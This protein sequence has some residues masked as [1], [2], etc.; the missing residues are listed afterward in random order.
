V[1]DKVDI[2]QFMV[3]RPANLPPAERIRRGYIHD[4]HLLSTGF[5][6]ADLFS[7]DSLSEIGRQVYTSVFCNGPALPTRTGT[8]TLTETASI[9]LALLQ[10]LPQYTAPCPNPQARDG[11]ILESLLDRSYVVAG[12]RVYLIPD[13]LRDV[14]APLIGVLPAVLAAARAALVEPPRTLDK[15]ALLDAVR[16]TLGAASLAGEVFEGASHSGAFIQTKRKLF[17]ALYLLYILRRRLSVRLEEIINGLRALHILEA[18]AIDEVLDRLQRQGQALTADQAILGALTAAFPS[19]KGWKFGPLPSGLPLIASLADLDV[20]LSAVPVVHPLFARLQHFRQPFNAIRPLGI[21]DLKVVKHWLTAYKPGEIAHIDNILKGETKTRVHRH[22]EKTEDVFSFSSEQQEE[23][24]RDV[25][26][27]DRFEMKRET[28]NVIKSDMNVNASANFGF[29]Y[30]NSGY[31]VLTGV[32]AGIAYTRSQS[33]QTKTTANFAREV[34][35]KAV[36]RVQSRTSQQRTTTKLFETEETNTHTFEN[37]STS[38]KNISGIYRWVDK[39]YTAQIFNYGKRLMF[40]F[41]LPE[42]GAFLVESRLRSYESRLDYPRPPQK[43]TEVALP[44]WLQ[45]MPASAITEQRYR[46]LS[47]TYD[48]SALPVPPVDKVVELVDAMTSK[49]EFAEGGIAGGGTYTARTYTCKLNAIGYRVSSFAMRGAV[50]FIGNSFIVPF[51][52]TEVSTLLDLPAARADRPVVVGVDPPAPSEVNRVEITL[53]GDTMMRLN[54][55]SRTQFAFGPGLDTAVFPVNGRR[56]LTDEVTLTLGFWD[57]GGFSLSFRARLDRTP[58]F[59]AEWQAAVRAVVVRAEQK[60]VDEA[61]RELTQAYNAQLSTYRNRLAE[62]RATAVNDVLQGQSEAANRQVILRELKRHCLSALTKEFDSVPADDVLTDL[63]TM[64]TRSVVSRSRQFR[65][66][67]RPNSASPTEVTGTF[68]VATTTVDFPVVDLDRARTKGRYI[69]F[70][71]QAFEWQQ[72][73]YLLYPYFWATPPKWIDL[74]NRSDDAD[75][76]LTAFLQAGAVRILVA[77]TP[78]YDEAVMHYLATG[79]PWEGGP[80][81]VIGDP[82]YLPLYEELR[83]QQDD[84]LNATAEG[85]SW[86]FTLP[87]SLVYL[88]NS[89]TPL[90]EIT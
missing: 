63:E 82:L 56:L 35:D 42:P 21:G 69:Q 10:K 44:A 8:A 78:A 68:A 83:K 22:L 5:E 6:A 46:Q 25:Q 67:E 30:E 36:K 84:L 81:P 18:L 71:E 2:L 17:D 16:L 62:L 41:V 40:E 79:E 77:V 50:G 58:E 52:G 23:T 90:P 70:L 9:L 74:M 73:S 76:F 34:V 37:K 45:Q 87:T 66:D 20:H 11:L 29:S 19:L 72:L 47:E 86:N 48:L 51:L 33:D 3:I 12:N 49:G 31:K 54:D 4:D 80:S 88:D 89:D 32:N 85:S 59:F 38:P 43:P 39:Q 7:Q 55:N 61:N 65:V 1:A 13:R 57:T 27:T 60:K 28:D 15:Q 75:P 26:T 14:S 64:G 53:A 24:Q